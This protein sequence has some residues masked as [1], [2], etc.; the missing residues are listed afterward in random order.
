M[1]FNKAKKYKILKPDLNNNASIFKAN[2]KLFE[3]IFILNK[4]KK[5]FQFGLDCFII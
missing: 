4:Y 5:T 3:S 2:K 1:L